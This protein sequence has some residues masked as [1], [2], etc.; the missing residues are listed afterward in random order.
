MSIQ[1]FRWFFSSHNV[2]EIQDR[3]E[4]VTKDLDKF[5]YIVDKQEKLIHV[6]KQN[7]V[8]IR[9]R[10]FCFLETIQG[11]T[12]SW[13]AIQKS[14]WINRQ[15]DQW[16]FYFISRI[17]KLH[18]SSDF[19]SSRTNTFA[20]GSIEF[21]VRLSIELIFLRSHRVVM[22]LIKILDRYPAVNDHFQR[23]ALC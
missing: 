7:F 10:P 2:E 23:F 15:I 5:A 22:K 9:T 12:F 19:R 8:S 4:G 20:R 3:L 14:T 17:E 21:F 16:L 11:C 6:H 1:H 13:S 18:R